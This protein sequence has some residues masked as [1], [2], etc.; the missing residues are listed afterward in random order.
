MYREHGKAGCDLPT[1]RTTELDTI[2]AEQFQKLVKHQR[3][4]IRLVVDSVTDTRQKEDHS[5]E[6]TRLQAQI[7]QLEDKQDKLLELSMA[8]AI[9]MQE[10]KKR[11][12][13]FNE[14]ITSLQT[15]TIALQQQE[16]QKQIAATDAAALEKALWADLSCKEPIQS[17]VVATILDHAVVCEDSDDKC[18]HLELYLRL[19]QTASAYYTR[20][21][22]AFETASSKN[23]TPRRRSRR[24]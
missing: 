6:I 1:I 8:D 4:I 10:F 2:L 13:R 11:N 9:T 21:R 12:S 18:I 14:Q 22:L 5:K 3:Q 16:Q 15:Q 7:Q 23:T 17:E 20:D 24:T 19:G